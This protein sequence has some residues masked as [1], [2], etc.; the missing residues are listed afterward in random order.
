MHLRTSVFDFS[1]CKSSIGGGISF[2]EERLDAND[3]LNLR[4]LDRISLRGGDGTVYTIH[5]KHGHAFLA[6]HVAFIL[7]RNIKEWCFLNERQVERIE[8]VSVGMQIARKH[9]SPEYHIITQVN[10]YHIIAV[11]TLFAQLPDAANWVQTV[12]AGGQSAILLDA[13]GPE[14]TSLIG[15]ISPK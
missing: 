10:Q 8:D 12:G 6:V 4:E 15:K 11:R 14:A 1:A 2:S 9:A 13:V 5:E 7:N 3:F